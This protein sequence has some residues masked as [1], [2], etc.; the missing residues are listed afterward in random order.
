MHGR[1]LLCT[2]TKS[3][4]L[5]DLNFSALQCSVAL[6]ECYEHWLINIFNCLGTVV[7]STREKLMRKLTILSS[8]KSLN[9]VQ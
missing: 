2:D 1:I 5:F 3:V 7:L 8:E 9:S 4:D 6:Q